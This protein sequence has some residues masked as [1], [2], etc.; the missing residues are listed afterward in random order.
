MRIGKVEVVGV[1]VID[2]SKI[3]VAVVTS[4]QVE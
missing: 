1:I 3:V 4:M 2:G